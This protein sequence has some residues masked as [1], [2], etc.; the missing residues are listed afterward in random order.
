MRAMRVCWGKHL[1]LLFYFLMFLWI[2]YYILPKR[3]ILT[4]VCI[5]CQCTILAS[6]LLCAQVLDKVQALYAMQ[7][8]SVMDE[9]GT[10]RA[11]A[12][13]L[14]GRFLSAHH[15]RYVSPSLN[16]VPSGVF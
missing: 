11:L 1:K 6:N 9:D 8:K 3:T 4:I 12:S 7:E 2:D 14:S 5:I 10:I 13:A 15:Q 16:K